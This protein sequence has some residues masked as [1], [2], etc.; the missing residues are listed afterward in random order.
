MHTT[1]MLSNYRPQRSSGQGYVFTRVC[2]SVHIPAYGQW[3]AGTHPTGM[4]SCWEFF[5]HKVKKIIL[6]EV[7]FNPCEDRLNI[8]NF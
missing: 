4:H 7:R 8:R 6:R 5:P 1:G 3:A 2:D